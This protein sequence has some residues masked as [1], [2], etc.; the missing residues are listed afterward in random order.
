MS[1]KS[2]SVIDQVIDSFSFMVR[3]HKIEVVKLG[4]NYGIIRGMDGL[5]S[6]Q[7][8]KDKWEG[9]IFIEVVEGELNNSRDFC[10]LCFY[11]AAEKD[12]LE[13]L[14]ETV[15]NLQSYCLDIVR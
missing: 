9:H 8:F 5:G 11:R 13:F 3:G 7:N 15:G 4:L 6:G 2:I 14:A 10:R 1:L 12:K